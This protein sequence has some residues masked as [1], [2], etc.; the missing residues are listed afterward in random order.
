[1]GAASSIGR[2]GPAAAAGCVPRPR[3]Q[4]A[5]CPGRPQLY[6]W[7]AT[8]DPDATTPEANRRDWSLVSV[9]WSVFVE[10]IRFISSVV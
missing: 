4:A 6:S 10:N 7:T 8:A 1:M 5:S 9:S 3:P 2:A